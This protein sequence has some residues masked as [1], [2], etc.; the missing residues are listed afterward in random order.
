MIAERPWQKEK[1]NKNTRDAAFFRHDSLS[2]YT[3]PTSSYALVFYI[4]NWMSIHSH[5]EQGSR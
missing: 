3:Q 2:S 1:K 5:I 4:V